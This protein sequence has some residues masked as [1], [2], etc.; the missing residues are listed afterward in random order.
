MSEPIIQKDPYDSRWGVEKLGKLWVH[1]KDILEH[2]KCPLLPA[3]SFYTSWN[4]TSTDLA[5]MAGKILR[6]LRF[7]SPW[8]TRVNFVSGLDSPGQFRLDSGKAS[9]DIHRRYRSNP[10]A[11]AAIL[12]HEITH[13]VLNAKACHEDNTLENERFTDFATV[14]FGLGVLVLN[15]KYASHTTDGFSL[16]KSIL[17]IMTLMLAGIGY[18]SN[19][20]RKVE[21]S[22]GYWK[23]DDYYMI[24]LGYVLRNNLNMDTISKYIKAGTRYPG[25]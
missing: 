20:F 13:L 16:F 18:F 8:E 3:Q 10:T 21:N 24:F 15:G 1:A 4:G 7:T 5:V 17:G 23:V 14:Y 12:A 2:G 9:I 6:Y 25:L 22:F 19:P 11:C